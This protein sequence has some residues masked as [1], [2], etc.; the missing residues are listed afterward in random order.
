M[1]I[2][3]IRRFNTH[4]TPDDAIIALQT[5]RDNERQH[6]LDTIQG[7]LNPKQRQLQHILIKAPR[8]FGKSYMARLAE[9]DSH[10]LAESGAT[11]SFALLP[12]EQRNVSSPASLLKEIRRIVTDERW[13]SVTSMWDDDEDAWKDAVADLDEALDDLFG[14]D[15]G[16]LVVAIENLDSLFR[17]VFKT[18]PDQLALRKWMTRKNNR[19]MVL[20][21]ATGSVDLDYSKPIF[22]AFEEIDL[23]PWTEDNCIEYF[24]QLREFK[25]DKLLDDEQIAKARAISTFIG[26]NP[27]LARFLGHVI[28]TENVMTVAET[29]DG[30]VD[31]LS[32]YYRRRID[33]LTGKTKTLLDALIRG[34]EPCSQS[35]LAERVGTEQS[36]IARAFAELKR[37]QIVVGKKVTGGRET[38]YHVTDRVFVHFYRTRYGGVVREDSPLVGITELLKTFFTTDEKRDQACAFLDSGLLKEGR[39]LAD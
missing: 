28:A 20:A 24:N 7:N 19:I 30:L 11:I 22:K 12:E 29:L 2:S 34:G 1:T 23:Q 9:I 36:R 15:D 39:L 32:D 4:D 8:G 3:T 37:N 5:G 27:R 21:T 26:G 17:D 35:E 10:G 16:L 31:D 13:D 25:E 6:V 33:D 14:D 18:D 38:L